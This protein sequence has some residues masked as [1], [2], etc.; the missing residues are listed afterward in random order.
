VI[1]ALSSVSGSDI[2]IGIDVSAPAHFI[3]YAILGGLLVLAFD[4]SD[5]LLAAAAMAS[6]YGVTDELHQLLVPGRMS[7]P[8]DWA[9]DTAGALAG[10]A[11]AAWLLRRH[12]GQDSTRTRLAARQ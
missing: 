2:R 9:V 12:A 3:E 5:R 8:A 10:A 1:F 11:L 4:R 6:A 7:D